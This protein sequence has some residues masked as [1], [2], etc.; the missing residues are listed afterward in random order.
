MAKARLKFF[1]AVASMCVAAVMMM[2]CAQ[3]GPSKKRLKF[4]L[5]MCR[6]SNRERARIIREC[7][8]TCEQ[9]YGTVEMGEGGH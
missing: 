5:M 4:L 3:S 6:E 8:V 2:G 1:L 9:S 7:N